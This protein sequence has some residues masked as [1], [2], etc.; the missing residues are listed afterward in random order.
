MQGRNLY[1]PDLNPH[2]VAGGYKLLPYTVYRTN[3]HISLTRLSSIDTEYA[4]II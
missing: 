2:G 1:P 3:Q 4:I